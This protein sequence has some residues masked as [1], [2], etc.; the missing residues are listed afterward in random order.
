MQEL[1][2][3]EIGSAIWGFFCRNVPVPPL[4]ISTHTL[5][6]ANA[7]CFFFFGKAYLA[8]KVNEKKMWQ[9]FIPGKAISKIRKRKR[10][11]LALSC[12][13]TPDE[14]KQHLQP[15]TKPP[16]NLSPLGAQPKDRKTSITAE[17]H[18]RI[19]PNMSIPNAP[20]PTDTTVPAAVLP[21]ITRPSRPNKS[22]QRTPNTKPLGDQYNSI[23]S[24]IAWDWLCGGNRHFAY[25]D[26]MTQPRAG[27]SPFPPANTACK[28]SSS[29]SSI[30]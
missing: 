14:E 29:E 7:H 27:P 26:N 5:P 1:K 18:C 28:P 3:S 19:T 17:N 12:K 2:R 9:P 30:S 20:K 15:P 24:R 23:E 10:R 25:Y 4:S 16:K 6:F 22:I 11:N 13:Q 21:N 8:R